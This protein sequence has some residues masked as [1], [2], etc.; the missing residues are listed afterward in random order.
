VPPEAFDPSIHSQIE[1]KEEERK[2][3]TRL[4]M[5]TEEVASTGN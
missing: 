1:A 5:G 2:G 3:E 4:G